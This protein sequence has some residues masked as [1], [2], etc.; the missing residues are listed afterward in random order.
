MSS[1]NVSGFTTLSNNTTL[2]SSLNVSGTTTLNNAATCLSSLNVVGNII[3][4]G[5]A[6]TN[7]NYGSITNPP[8]LT[9]YDGWTK[10]GNDIYQT[11]FSTGNIGIG[12]NSSLFKTYI[13]TPTYSKPL[14]VLNAGLDPGGGTGRTIGQPLLG[15]GYT[16][17]GGL[18]DYYGIGLGYCSLPTRK[19]CC[20]IG[21][22]IT[23]TAAG[24]YG[25]LVFSA[26]NT[27]VNTDVAVERM[28]I[29]SNG[30]IK[31]NNNTTLFS[32]LNVSGL[33]TLSNN[34]TCISSLNV[35]GTT[36]LNN[37][38]TCISSFNVSGVTTLLN[39]VNIKGELINQ[40]WK[41][42]NDS[43]YC[44]LNGVGGGYFNFAA[45]NLYSSGIIYASGDKLN[46]LDT[47]NQYKI[48]LWGA[49]TYGFGIASETLQYSSYNYHRFYNSTNNATTFMINGTGNITCVGI[50]NVSSST[51]LN[52]AI[53]AISSLNVSGLTTLSNNT[54]CLSTLNV[55]GST[56]LSGGTIT[57]KILM[58]GTVVND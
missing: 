28:R 55:S 7:L 34:T 50:L 16:G 48:N 29:M 37:A 33:T 30:N 58:N 53:T 27:T 38:T 20:E 41:F 51:T 1:L 35:S 9:V 56:T 25:D 11:N 3:G 46:F 49:N 5:T 18:G 32:A 31:I 45:N 13:H 24:E 47:L 6:L 42:T 36:T 8:D 14:L 52:N 43:D 54:T 44:R 10:S 21:C 19:Y 40:Y 39:N 12:I 57:G 17:F 22:V 2:S 4:S 23:N 15:I 26:R